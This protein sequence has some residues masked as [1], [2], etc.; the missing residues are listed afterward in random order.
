MSELI[1]VNCSFKSKLYLDTD[2]ELNTPPI[3]ESGFTV[4]KGDMGPRGPKGDVGPK[5]DAGPEGPQGLKGDVGLQGEVGPE[6]LMGPEGPQGPKGDVGPEGPT[7]PP[8]P[9][10]DVGPP[11]AAGPQGPIGPRG[12]GLNLPENAFFKTT[13]TEL[14]F[15]FKYTKP[16]F[17][18]VDMFTYTDQNNVYLPLLPK[19]EYSSS[20][21]LIPAVSMGLLSFIDI[22]CSVMDEDLDG[23][24]D[25]DAM[26]EVDVVD[27]SDYKLI[28]S[29]TN[30]VSDSGTTRF[31]NLIDSPLPI[32]DANHTFTLYFRVAEGG[33]KVL[34]NVVESSGQICVKGYSEV[35]ETRQFMHSYSIK[36]EGNRALFSIKGMDLSRES[37]MLNGPGTVYADESGLLRIAF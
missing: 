18:T 36:R 28:F 3:I 19:G 7:G 23:Q 25:G 33:V 14:E 26:I 6:G 20:L 12:D 32:V 5:G 4:L 2:M 1:N 10:G 11:G 35:L 27:N 24:K 29:S 13:D 30:M 37:A 16:V 34:L 9:K 31:Y 15:G 21:T 17:T 22:K 8:G